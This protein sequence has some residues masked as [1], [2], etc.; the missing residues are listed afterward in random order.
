MSETA[1]APVAGPEFSYD[2]ER[3]ATRVDRVHWW[4]ILACIAVHQQLVHCYCDQQ[5][6]LYCV[7][8]NH[9]V[10]SGR[11]RIPGP[12]PAGLKMLGLLPDGPDPV[13][14]AAADAA[15]PSAEKGEG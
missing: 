4:R 15:E 11:D 13:E 9:Q 1:T 5:H 3:L 10:G 2:G 6:R 7:H 8:C 14:P 12:C